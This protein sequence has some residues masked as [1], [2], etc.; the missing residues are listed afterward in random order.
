MKNTLILLVVIIFNVIAIISP[1]SAIEE[2]YSNRK[3]ILFYNLP[4]EFD[5]TAI[6]CIYKDHKGYIW[7]ATSEGLVKYD[8]INLIVY[9]NEN[10]NR[11]LSNN[12]VTSIVEDKF[13]E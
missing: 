12:I 2:S 1:V 7:F 4:V 6:R 10:P 9:R 3:N 13:K 8:G 5:Y 11:F